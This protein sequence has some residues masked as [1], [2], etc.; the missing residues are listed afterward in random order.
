MKWESLPKNVQFVLRKW[1]RENESA[2]R[3]AAINV[4][5]WH[6]GIGNDPDLTSI[7]IY[8]EVA[9]TPE[10]FTI[11][12]LST[13]TKKMKKGYRSTQPISIVPQSTVVVADF[14]EERMAA[15]RKATIESNADVTRQEMK[16][17]I[18]VRRSEEEEWWNLK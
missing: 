14:S 15:V 6:T 1:M 13:Q 5:S 9:R 18:Q 16:A 11:V 7:V 12:K 8:V 2:P 10:S 3:T 4:D 17:K